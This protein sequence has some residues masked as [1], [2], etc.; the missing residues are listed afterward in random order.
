MKSS[1]EITAPL[2][3]LECEQRL[4]RRGEEWTLTNCLRGPSA[5]SLQDALIRSQ[6]SYVDPSA[7]FAAFAGDSTPGVDPEQLAYFAASVFWRAAVHTWTVDKEHRLKLTLGP[8][9]EEL[10]LFLLDQSEFPGMRFSS[11]A[12]PKRHVLRISRLSPR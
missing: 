1:R 10:R 2:L 11:S 8:Y 3:C 5:F 6:P 12:L 9:E 7:A 4:N